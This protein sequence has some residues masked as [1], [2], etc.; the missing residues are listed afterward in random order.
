MWMPLGWA[1]TF[2]EGQET[3]NRVKHGFCLGGSLNGSKQ[4][5][6][7]EENLAPLISISLCVSALSPVSIFI[8]ILY[9]VIPRLF[10]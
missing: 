9:L 3:P 8:F 4:Q 10:I 2:P 5:S 7:E 6:K 1:L